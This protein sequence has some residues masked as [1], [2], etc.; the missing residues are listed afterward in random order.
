M[1]FVIPVALIELLSEM[2]ILTVAK[3]NRDRAKALA[4][5]KQ[6]ALGISRD[7]LNEILLIGV[8]NVVF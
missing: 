4:S 3:R 1:D 8:R 7:F 5:P 6:Q 2:Y